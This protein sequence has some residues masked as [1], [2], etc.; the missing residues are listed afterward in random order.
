MGNGKRCSGRE[1]SMDSGDKVGNYLARSVCLG[2]GRW[3]EWKKIEL[4][5]SPG[6]DCK[7]DKR[8]E[9]LTC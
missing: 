2:K 6:P 8:A 5:G 4:E 7:P 3:A 9:I 1:N